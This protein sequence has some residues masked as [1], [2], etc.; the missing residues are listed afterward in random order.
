MAGVLEVLIGLREREC[1]RPVVL[2]PLRRRGGAVG[3]ILNQAPGVR[4]REV[5]NRGPHPEVRG[6]AT[7]GIRA[8][9][10]GPT[11][12]GRRRVH[13]SRPQHDGDHRTSA[14]P[15]HN[16]TIVLSSRRLG[17]GPE[18]AP[19]EARAPDLGAVARVAE[20]EPAVMRRAGLPVPDLDAGGAVGTGHEGL[21]EDQESAH[22]CRA[23]GAITP[24]SIAM[25]C[26]VGCGIA[27]HSGI[28]RTQ[29]DTTTIKTQVA[30]N[31][32]KSPA[33]QP[34]RRSQ[35]SGGGGIRTRGPRERTPVF[36]TGAFDRSA[37]PP[38]IAQT[39]AVRP[40]GRDGPTRRSL[41]AALAAR[42]RSSAT[43]KSA[44]TVRPSAGA[45]AT[46]AGHADVAGGA[47]AVQQALGAL[48]RLALVGAREDDRELLAARAAGDVGHAHAVAQDAGELDAG[49]RR[50]R[51]GR[52]CR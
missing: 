22:G 3:G 10:R 11:G 47:D 25:G 34:H 48:A 26:A 18:R 8:L 35:V 45:V 5:A 14:S 24:S 40:R 46:P 4:R 15:W 33:S 39:V 36:K 23:S 2:R 21:L 16:E 19:D 50:R 29:P 49:P 20:A 27:R 12:R 9:R 28:Q 37:T 1:P 38:G 52:A 17:Q 42:R 32:A 51:G 30:T 41:P 43:W 13:A 44:S 7:V 6:F 31:P